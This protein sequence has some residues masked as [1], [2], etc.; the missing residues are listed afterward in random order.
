MVGAIEFITAYQDY[1]KERNCPECPV[2]NICI[3][4]GCLFKLT[5]ADKCALVGIVMASERERKQNGESTNGN[6]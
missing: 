2:M 6:D 3:K 5:S 4:R 1:C